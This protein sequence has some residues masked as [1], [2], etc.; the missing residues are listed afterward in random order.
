MA[1]RTYKQRMAPSK[2][3]YPSLADIVLLNLNDTVLLHL[4]DTVVLNLHDTLVL[5]LN[6]TVLHLNFASEL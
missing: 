5:N 3:A 4:N 1:V 6:D 2:R